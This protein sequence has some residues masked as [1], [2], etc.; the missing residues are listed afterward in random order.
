MTDSVESGLVTR[1]LAEPHRAAI[2][3]ALREAPSGLDV[4]EVARRFAL[5]PNTIRWHLG[6]L[7]DAG[8]VRS[9]RVHSGRPGRPRLVFEAVAEEGAGTE[10]FRFLATMLAGALA[11]TPGGAGAAERTGESWGRHL[12]DRPAPTERISGAVA[13]DR[14]VALLAQ[15]GFAPRLVGSTIEMHH[16]PFAELV[17][18]YGEIVCTV[19]RGLIRGALDE[20]GGVVDLKALEPWARPGVCTA[21]LEQRG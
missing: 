21:A 7:A 17:E 12:V 18:P 2:L 10:G 6:H 9:R 16:C 19:H 5:H 14:V 13:A 3:E 8:L 15:H 11:D 4:P 1:T 20:L